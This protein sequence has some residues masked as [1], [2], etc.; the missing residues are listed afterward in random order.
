MASEST[1]KPVK[2]EISIKQFQPDIIT[3][4]R[5]F[6]RIEIKTCRQ[7]MSI[8]FNQTCL[9]KEMLPKY[10]YEKNISS[11]EEYFI[12][13]LNYLSMLNISIFKPSLGNM[14]F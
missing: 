8:I 13:S 5:R 14:N 9:N 3:S 6:E 10:K 7:R 4:I 11:L 2:Y 12:Y 1:W